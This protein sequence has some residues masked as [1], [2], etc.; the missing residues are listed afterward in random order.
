MTTIETPRLLLRQFRESD[1]DSYA[2]MCADEEV[3]RYIGDGCALTRAEAWRNMAMILGHWQL[4]GYGLWAVE[5]KESGLLVGRAGFFNPEGWPGFEVGW[6]LG[7]PYWG[8]GF[9]T[10]AARTALDYAFT[11]LDQTR[12]I[13]LIRPG[14]LRSIRVAERLGEKYETAIVLFGAEALVYS[15]NRDA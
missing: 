11:Q 3:M 5:E 10:E 14:N 13:S 9:A 1:I 8:K 7:R 15:I 2:E 4:R 12:V 6:L